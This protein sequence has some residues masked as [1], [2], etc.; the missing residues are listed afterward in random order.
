[1]HIAHSS[2]C[3]LGWIYDVFAM[4]AYISKY[5]L[6]VALCDWDITSTS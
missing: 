2:T 4:S 3:M 1:M 6:D 5:A